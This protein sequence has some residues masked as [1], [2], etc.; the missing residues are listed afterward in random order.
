M[1]QLVFKQ[2]GGECCRLARDQSTN[3]SKCE[4]TTFFLK[5]R[6]G[7]H[8]K[9][10]QQLETVPDSTTCIHVTREHMITYIT[11]HLL[12]ENRPPVTCDVC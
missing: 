8:L 7:F 3:L 6:I 2:F 10:K 9:P 11:C 12:Y 4:G 5:E 1:Q